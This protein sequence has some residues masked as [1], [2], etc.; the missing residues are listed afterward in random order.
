[1]APAIWDKWDWTKILYIISML[2]AATI[3]SYNGAK[4]VLIRSCFKAQ[5]QHRKA[6]PPRPS[7]SSFTLSIAVIARM[8]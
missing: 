8:D 6:R 3:Y 5:D 1:M 2:L 7:V 4:I